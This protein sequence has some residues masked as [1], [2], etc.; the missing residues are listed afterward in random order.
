MDQ[1]QP[2]SLPLP[3]KNC[4]SC[5]LPARSVKLD[6]SETLCDRHRILRDFKHL[7]LAMGFTTRYFG[8]IQE[9]LCM[10]EFETAS[11]PGLVRSIKP[12]LR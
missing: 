6:G 12:E 1:E 4:D 9:R 3:R 8:C 10:D 7:G 11:V 2:Y 5:M